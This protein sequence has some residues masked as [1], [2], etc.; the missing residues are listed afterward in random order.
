MKAPFRRLP[1]A[2]ALTGIMMFA[3]TGIAAA[4]VQTKTINTTTG[5]CTKDANGDPVL[6]GGGACGTATYGALGFTGNMTFS[7]DE[8]GTT[9]ALADIICVHTPS[10]GTFT[11]IGFDGSGNVINTTGSSA[12]YHFTLN[13]DPTVTETIPSGKLCADGLYN[14]FTAAAATTGTFVITAASMP[15]SLLIDGITAANAEAKFAAN[16]FNSLIN[17]VWEQKL[18][19]EHGVIQASSPSVGLPKG[20]PQDVPEAPLSVLLVL[21]GGVTTAWYVSRKLRQ[22]VPLKAA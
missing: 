2:I 12:T 10:N 17:K 15:Y 20:P 4:D 7:A 18:T 14:P 6:V 13:G 11:S 8:V 16:G 1:L 5:E 21:T 3:L 22:S 19:N 9:Q